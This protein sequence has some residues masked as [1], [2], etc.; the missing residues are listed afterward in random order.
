[1]LSPDTRRT[2]ES[3]GEALSSTP[4]GQLAR[5]QIHESAALSYHLSSTRLLAH[6]LQGPSADLRIDL[7][8][9]L[10]S[11]SLQK[12]LA[13]ERLCITLQ[14][15]S[16]SRITE[17]RQVAHLFN[18]AL[19]TSFKVILQPDRVRFVNDGALRT[20]LEEHRGVDGKLP[21]NGARRWSEYTLQRFLE[22]IYPHLEGLL[23]TAVPP[24]R[25]AVLPTS[26]ARCHPLHVRDIVIPTAN[27]P[28]DLARLLRSIR[29]SL[30]FY[31]Y[32]RDSIRIRVVDT[33]PDLSTRHSVCAVVKEACSRGLQVEYLGP[34]LIRAEL[35]SI[36]D[37]LEGKAQRAFRTLFMR[38]LFA[39]GEDRGLPLTIGTIRNALS[40]IMRDT[41]HISL[42]DDMMLHAP[43]PMLE[44][45]QCSLERCAE[46]VTL[47]LNANAL[48]DY[49]RVDA[50]PFSQGRADLDWF[51]TDL[52][53]IVNRSLDLPVEEGESR[54]VGTGEVAR[55]ASAAPRLAVV[56]AYLAGATPDVTTFFRRF[57][58][59]ADERELTGANA[60][61][62]LPVEI[63]AV[64]A[65]RG[66]SSGTMFA[67]TNGL[68]VPFL[69]ARAYED[70][71]Q[72]QLS[73][74]MFQ[75]ELQHQAGV[76]EHR[77]H[78]GARVMHSDQYIDALLGYHLMQKYISSLVPNSFVMRARACNQVQLFKTLGDK[79]W[80]DANSTE[81]AI[82]SSELAAL[83][84]GYQ[85]MGEALRSAGVE[86][87]DTFMRTTEEIGARIAQR[88]RV[89][90]KANALL[91]YY[92]PEISRA[93]TEV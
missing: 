7:R 25:L 21:Y 26:L 1:M 45:Y 34:E 89:L 76:V 81:S 16:D 6:L 58:E 59:T 61:Y 65:H 44:Q 14:P 42:D 52:L 55:F 33:S 41:P 23:R 54:I 11:E 17:L 29:R 67:V 70:V 79:L 80:S 49:A 66:Y 4:G 10:K 43:V 2:R 13:N 24:H 82:A 32:P 78:V 8:H 9:I 91:Y 38:G 92:W 22:K 60:S 77:R 15:L 36:A 62:A 30:E 74:L 57:I 37:R 63:P 3:R 31:G 69:D 40:L 88:L 27:R 51:P 47:D 12:V 75:G 90:Q 71:A 72:S 68:T 39:E 20:F 93:A 87:A 86:G 84:S 48:N 19:G 18:A 64:T 50:R 73:H 53:G 28:D 56:R 35:G 46:R 85:Q 83:I 5:S